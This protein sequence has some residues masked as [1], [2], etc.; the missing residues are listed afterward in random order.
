MSRE[1]IKKVCSIVLAG[2]ATLL[3]TADPSSNTDPS[4][5]EATGH[6]RALAAK[7]LTE[8]KWK[9]RMTRHGMVMP[10]AK[11]VMHTFYHFDDDSG[12]SNEAAKLLMV[13]WATAWFRAGWDVK[14][15]TMKNVRQHPDYDKYRFFLDMNNPFGT[16]SSVSF[17]RWFA[18][19]TISEGGW[20]SDF[21]TFPLNNFTSL[22]GKNLPNG[23]RLTTH[24]GAMPALVSGSHDEWNRMAKFLVGRVQ[25]K[26]KDVRARGST[27]WSDLQVLAELK[28]EYETKGQERF[29]EMTEWAMPGSE[30]VA[31][32]EL[33]VEKCRELKIKHRSAVHFSR[34]EFEKAV[35]KGMITGPKAA[36]EKRD[37]KSVV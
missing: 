10:G 13:E 4:Y 2:I 32:G 11:P 22:D 36:S 28:E 35:S 6:L 20:M 24:S 21:D 9:P 1:R 14:I 30:L 29:F 19:G 7:K 18:M 27:K 5:L 15:L 8:I 16:H 25:K 33:D 12:V 23:G 31:L 34:E 17:W 37:R 26:A 3:L